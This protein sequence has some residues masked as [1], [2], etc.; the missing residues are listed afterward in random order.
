MGATRVFPLNYP[1]TY[2]YLGAWQN[3]R[4][5]RTFFSWL[6]LGDVGREKGV[7]KREKWG[8]RRKG[9]ERPSSSFPPFF[10]W[11]QK[12]EWIFLPSSSFLWQAAISGRGPKTHVRTLPPAA[13]EYPH[14][15]TERDRVAVRRGRT[16]SNRTDPLH[17]FAP[18]CCFT[19]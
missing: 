14:T 5:Q 1:T 3:T 17:F 7:K 11:H 10:L 13:C 19:S 12:G 8:R 4:P 6:A 16:I 2:V 15:D 18:S 9:G